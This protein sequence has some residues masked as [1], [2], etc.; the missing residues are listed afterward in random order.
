MNVLHSAAIMSQAVTAFLNALTPEQRAKATFPFDDPERMNWFYTPHDRKGLPLKEM[1]PTQ[2]RL[3]FALLNAGLSGRGYIKAMNI[4]SLEEVLHILER[5]EGPVRDAELY[6]FTVF[7]D[8]SNGGAWG[9]RI[10]GHHL[11]HNFT[12]VDGQVTDVPS[13]FGAN[14]AEIRQG[15]RKG[16]RTLAQEED[17]ARELVRSLSAG[18]LEDALVDKVAYA[19]ILT[20]NSRQ[21][22]LNGQPCGLASGRLNTS[23][24]DMLQALVEEYAR[25]VPEALAA[26]REQ[27]I[28]DA[29]GQLH[30]AWAGGREAGEPHYYRVQ[31]TAFLIEYDNTQDDANHIHSVWR[32]FEGDFGRDLLRE[33]YQASHGAM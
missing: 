14:P 27:R 16:L 2:Q 5:G 17:L 10:D 12:V 1:S 3:A 15:P 4:M 33:H 29:G 20:T 22:A 6:F 32:D 24:R 28:R 25:N 8:P 11:C 23:Q 9:Y 18:Q 21:A 19:D 7:G 26:S 30:F 13:F 31:S